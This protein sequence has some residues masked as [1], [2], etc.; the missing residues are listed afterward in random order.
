MQRT[1]IWF[2]NDLRI[3]DH[4]PLHQAFV[5]QHPTIGIYC[6]DPRNYT[7]LAIGI[8]K[9]GNVRAQFLLESVAQLKQSLR[10]L[11]SDLFIVFGKP[12]EQIPIVCKALAIDVVAYHQEIAPEETAIENAVESV[13]Q[14]DNVQTKR[15]WNATLVH[16]EDLPFSMPNLPELFTDFR[17]KIEG[18]LSIRNPFPTPEKLFPIHHNLQF[19]KVTLTTLG[20]TPFAPSPLGVLDFKGGEKEALKRL[21]YYL[22]ETDYLSTYKKTRNGFLGQNYSSKFSPWLAVGSIS[23][24]TI[25]HE[26]KQYEQE[27][28]QNEST[29]WLVFELL[30]RDYFKW[31]ASKHQGQLF[32]L[33][34]LQKLQIQWKEDEHQFAVWR[35]GNTGYPIIDANMRE[36]LQ[37][38]FMSN[39]GRQLVASFLTKNLGINWLWGAQWFESQLIDYDV[40]SNYGNWNYAAGVGNDARGFRYFNILKQAQDYDANGMFVKHWLPELKRLPIDKVHQPYK[41]SANEN[42]L[43]GFNLGKDYPKPVIDLDQSV[44]EMERLYNSAVKQQHIL[45]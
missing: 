4:E 10:L 5:H 1:L 31:I 39:R 45:V 6:F 13:L 15:Y 21:K 44:K 3:T 38:G 27:R 34:G 7:S 30:W 40:C 17:K 33:E 9:T 35:A 42:M 18:R 37:T 12:E 29:Y 24:L 26:V 36:L 8:P 2:R 32:R 22:W 28:V 16:K 20:L 11:G 23:A 41:M 25:Y 43:Y 14:K 19:G